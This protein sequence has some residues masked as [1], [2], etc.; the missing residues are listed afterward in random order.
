MLRQTGLPICKAVTLP[1]ILNSAIELWREMGYNETIMSDIVFS[2]TRVKIGDLKPWDGNPRQSTKAQARKILKS[3][4]E[5]GQVETVAVG[6]SLEV[7]DGHQRLSALL[8]VHGPDYEIDARQSNR[9]LTEDERK[10]LVLVLHAGAVGSWDWDIVSSWD[11]PLLM[12]NGLDSEMLKE[13]KRDT[14]AL[15]NFLRSEKDEPIDAE[16]QI[17]RAEELLEKWQVKT[18]DLWQIGE[19]RLLCG[20]NRD[21]EGVSALMLFEKLGSQITDPPYGV[22][23]VK[24]EMVG[25]DFGVAKKGKYAPVVGDE[26]APDISHVVSSAPLSII[27]GGNYFADKLPPTNSWLVWD[28]RSDSGIENTFADCELAWSNIGSPA[29]VFRQLWNGMIRDGEREKR[30]HPTQK[31]VALFQW[32]VQKTN[33]IVGDWYAG[34]GTMLVAC[35]NLSR[36]CRAIEISPAYCAVI[37]ERMVTAFPGIEITRLS[38][39]EDRQRG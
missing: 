26:V 16:P 20:D 33:G 38:T 9:A 24:S 14:A 1:L 35:E 27:W 28:K 7:Y 2:N 21:A 25:A 18:G 31:S 22:N 3:F 4:D 23:I 17:D 10:R 19:H 13:W 32:C 6:P 39:A 29:R 30:V 34:S 5:F 37:L 8:T 11:A 36:K 15:D 12:K